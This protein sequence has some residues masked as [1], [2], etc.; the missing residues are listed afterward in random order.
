MRFNV[1]KCK[2]NLGDSLVE[3]GKLEQGL[4]EFDQAVKMMRELMPERKRTSREDHGIM[5]Q[6]RGMIL[7]KNKR[8]KEALRD[9]DESVSILEKEI[10]EGKR[11]YLQPNLDRT[12]RL[13]REVAAGQI[14]KD[15]P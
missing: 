14:P 13:R 3:G 1:A 8:M 15:K 4:A 10:E 9:L 5:L 7:G 11:T 2:S 6:V 12:L